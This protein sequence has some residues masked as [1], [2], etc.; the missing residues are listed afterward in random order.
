MPPDASNY[1]IGLIFNQVKIGKNL[2]IAYTSRLLNQ[3][4][5]NYSMMG[6]ETISDYRKVR[7]ELEYVD[8]ERTPKYQ[9]YNRKNK[10]CQRHGHTQKYCTKTPRCMKCTGDH[11]STECAK[12]IK[13]ENVKCVNCSEKHPTNYKGCMAYKTKIYSMQASSSNQQENSSFA[14]LKMVSRKLQMMNTFDKLEIDSYSCNE[15]ESSTKIVPHKKRQVNVLSTSEHEEIE[16]N[17]IDRLFQ[18]KIQQA[19]SALYPIIS[20]VPQNSV[21]VPL[22][23]TLHTSNFP[24]TKNTLIAT[25]EPHKASNKLQQHLNEI[26]Y[27]LKTQRIKINST[28]STCVTFT[29]RK[30]IYLAVKLNNDILPQQE[31]IKYLDRKLLW[32]TYIRKKIEQLIKNIEKYGGR[33]AKNHSC[34]I[35]FISTS[36][37]LTNYQSQ[38]ELNKT[39]LSRGYKYASTGKPTYSLSDPTKIPDLLDFC[40]T[41]DNIN[42]EIPLKTKNNIDQAVEVLTKLIQAAAYVTM[43]ETKES[44]NAVKYL[45]VICEKIA[46]KRNDGK[47]WQNNKQLED[48]KKLNKLIKELKGFFFTKKLKRP[49]KHI[50]PIR[51]KDNIWARGNCDISET[52]AEHLSEMFKPNE[53]P[54]LLIIT[55]AL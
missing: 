38:L 34:S 19:V 23:Y 46:E 27:W 16:D 50:P 36:A 12:K 17:Y 43:P 53:D 20:G 2:A 10:R 6:K 48:K 40:T 26:E 11:L 5:P 8:V 1:T 9:N 39:M 32:K 4:K 45:L 22:L 25:F 52:F 13:D 33:S 49:R 51:T 29:T 18:V 37:E 55:V 21:L 15:S 54:M 35:L 44:I 3:A 24:I 41:K 42:L 28:K 30:Q 7:Q 14:L 31:T 47:K